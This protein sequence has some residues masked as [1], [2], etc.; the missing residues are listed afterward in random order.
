MKRPSYPIRLIR[1]KLFLIPFFLFYSWVLWMLFQITYD[2]EILLN[3]LYK[4]KRSPDYSKEAIRLYRGMMSQELTR[5]RIG[6]FYRLIEVLERAERKEEIVTV[7]EKMF[8]LMP[9]DEYLRSSLAIALHNA[10]RYLEAEEH[11]I[12][13]LKEDRGG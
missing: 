13:L 3:R 9:E 1:N 10:G 7:L 4:S 2:N 11:F 5:R 8:R 6:S 12:K